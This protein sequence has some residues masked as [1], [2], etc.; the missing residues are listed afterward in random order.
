MFSVYGYYSE[1]QFFVFSG[2]CNT[3]H[4]QFVLSLSSSVHTEKL[5]LKRKNSNMK[6]SAT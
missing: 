4:E 3:R 5:K 6:S 1:Q 2:K